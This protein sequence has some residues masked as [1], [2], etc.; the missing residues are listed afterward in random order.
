MKTANAVRRVDANRAHLRAAID[1]LRARL[2]GDDVVA[3]RKTLDDAAAALTSPSPLDMLQRIFDLSNFEHD[4][5]LMC[6]ACELD[7]SFSKLC[8]TLGG[9]PRPT[10]SLAL[11]KLSDAHWDALTPQAPLRRWQLI[12]PDAGDGL[13]TARPLS[14]DERVLHY[15][16]GVTAMDARLS[17]VLDTLDAVPLI[18][19]QK[20]LAEYGA[21]HLSGDALIQIS[22]AD[23]PTLR[24]IAAA[25]CDRAGFHVF[26]LDARTIPH[27]PTEREQMA[28]LWEREAVLRGAA[29]CVDATDLSEPAALRTLNNW[30]NDVQG[31]LLLISRDPVPLENTRR[32][33]R[34]S[35]PPPDHAE[36]IQ[37]WQSALGDDAARLNG[38][39]ERLASQFALSAADVQTV[40]DDAR[41][42]HATDDKPLSDA[43]WD[44]CR[45]HARPQLDDLAQ[46]IDCVATWDDLVLPDAQFNMLREIAAQVRGRHTVYNEWG[47]AAKSARGLGISALF[48]GVSGTGKTM[49]AEVLANDLRLDL[50]RIDLSA[51]VSKYIGETEKNLRR[52]FD[53]AERGG[54]ILLFDEADAL[55][56]KR[57]EVKD[58][59]DR[60]ANIEVSYLL[61][62]MEAYQGL[63]IL[64]TNMRDAL[65]DA[66]IRRIRFI[67]TFDFPSVTERARIWSKVFPSQTP[68][69]NLEP[70][71]LA[72]L[73][74]SGGSIRNIA[75]RAAFLAA[76]AGEPVRMTHI[77]RAAHNEYTKQGKSLSGSEI[78]GWR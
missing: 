14:I 45:T 58:S 18:A 33:V 67:V 16:C 43:L 77:L 26:A 75:L 7:G 51:V 64:T 10:L 71:K 68:T 5:L 20:A 62:R 37:L 42:Q 74:V 6:A 76:D 49:S 8:E 46:R 65:D 55:F 50:Y 19:S 22:G 56:G 2:G 23:S 73:N 70:E 9:L 78:R 48:A 39:L 28:R 41:Q 21:A 53:A 35:V 61:Q 72:Q 32:T 27:D 66:F 40:N 47:F 4:L 25:L 30:L 11:G 3:A 38:T 15:L 17:G 63:A 24:Q 12:R 69:D 44:A 60:H 52:I 59:H 36:Q 34:L 54:V 29:L 13:L 31:M 57:S 1:L